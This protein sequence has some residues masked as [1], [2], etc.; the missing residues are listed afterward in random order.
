MQHVQSLGI[1]RAGEQ[2]HS[3][4]V[5]TRS[6]DAGHQAGCD[7]IAAVHEYN[8]YGSRRRLCR[9]RSDVAAGR[10]NDADLTTNQIIRERRQPIR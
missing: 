9:K 10:D 2:A 3:C 6:I 7:R 4:D 5:A 8:R 1:D